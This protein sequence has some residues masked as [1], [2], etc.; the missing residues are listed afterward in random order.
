YHYKLSEL[1]KL[2]SEMQRIEI[3]IASS[4][5]AARGKRTGPTSRPAAVSPADVAKF[6]AEMRKMLEEKRSLESSL[7]RLKAR[8]GSAHAQV[9]DAQVQVNFIESAIAKRL[10]EIGHDLP[11]PLAATGASGES[12]GLVLEQVSPEAL[13]QRLTNLTALRER[14]RKEAGELAEL[15]TRVRKATTEAA[16]VRT[17]L[18]ETSA[19][20]DA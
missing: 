9:R 7:Y 10:E 4:D 18:T 19:R 14:A 8:F 3:A 6:D 2:E 1:N 17:A 15:G 20:A 5:A 13:R 16:A 11:I 12:A